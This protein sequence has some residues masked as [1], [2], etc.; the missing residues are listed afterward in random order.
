MATVASSIFWELPM[1]GTRARDIAEL[2][3]SNCGLVL[4][5]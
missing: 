1:T 5:K 2:G 4:L 3:G